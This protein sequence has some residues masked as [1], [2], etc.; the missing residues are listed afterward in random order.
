MERDQAQRFQDEVNIEGDS[1]GTTDAIGYPRLGPYTFG[2]FSPYLP[3]SSIADDILS[4]F[5]SPRTE[6]TNE[7]LQHPSP[8]SAARALEQSIGS[9]SDR[10]LALEAALQSPQ[11]VRDSLEEAAAWKELGDAQTQDEKEIA[12]MRA[13]EEA[14]RVYERI[15]EQQGGELGREGAEAMGQAL[16]VSA[17]CPFCSLLQS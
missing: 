14:V 3:S 1:I 11:M 12:G 2:S 9:L 5:F 16:M 6:K 15:R 7:Y 13:L 10:A 17:T 4:A 8:L